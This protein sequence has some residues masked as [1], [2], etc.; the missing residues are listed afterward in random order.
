M[1]LSQQGYTEL[2]ETAKGALTSLVTYG[3]P[4]VI[5]RIYRGVVADY[6]REWQTAAALI[7]VKHY[8]EFVPL[9]AGKTHLEAIKL[10]RVRAQHEHGLYIGLSDAKNFID[11]AQGL[12]VPHA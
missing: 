10:L 11:R 2:V 3:G 8:E 7:F 9:L 5:E 6:K 4:T 12:V 1:S